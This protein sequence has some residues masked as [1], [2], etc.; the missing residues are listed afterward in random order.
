MIQEK[1]CVSH[2]DTECRV[3]DKIKVV[4]T[5]KRYEELKDLGEK[6]TLVAE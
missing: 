2:W 4:T 6:V 3:N 1:L 5:L